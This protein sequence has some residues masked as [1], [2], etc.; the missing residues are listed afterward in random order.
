MKIEKFKIEK[1]N[2]L[3]LIQ[4]IKSDYKREF[5]DCFIES[6]SIND[7]ISINIFMEQYFFRNNSSTGLSVS[8][9][10]S[11]QK[12]EVLVVSLGAGSGILDLSWG[13]ENKSVKGIHKFFID[14]GFECTYF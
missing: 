3:Q 7:V 9:L 4:I 13:A 12:I 2:C 11:E 8:L 6:T 14:H 1:E 5:P 10:A